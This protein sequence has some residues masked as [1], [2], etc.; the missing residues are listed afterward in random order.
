MLE[1]MQRSMK[2]YPPNEYA[3]GAVG[4][5]AAA[6]LIYGFFPNWYV[7]FWA[8]VGTF[9]FM[10][11]LKRFNGPPIVVLEWAVV[12]AL[13]PVLGC[14]VF[15]VCVPPFASALR[16]ISELTA[17]NSNGVVV[18]PK[19]LTPP[20]ASPSKRSDPNKPTANVI[21]GESFT[22]LRRSERKVLSRPT[23]ALR[24][25]V[26]APPKAIAIVTP[27]NEA[28]TEEQK[29]T[30]EFLDRDTGRVEWSDSKNKYGMIASDTIQ[31][32]DV[33][34]HFSAIVD[35]SQRLFGG[36]RVAY[37]LYR[38]PQGLWA[39]QVHVLQAQ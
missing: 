8:V 19:T 29:E 10:V 35:G 26:A 5:A 37:N 33:L 27:P 22:F 14:A 12:L 25:E 16:S 20:A 32:K 15:W 39:E 1:L 21:R 23:P 28:G 24:P 31:G 4:I 13:I 38:G 18:V 9:L 11:I 30:V 6:A 2:V 17:K 7:A 34:V 3:T 36:D